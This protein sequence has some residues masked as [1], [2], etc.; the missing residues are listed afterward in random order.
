M[1]A[2]SDGWDQ[3]DG[4]HTLEQVGIRGESFVESDAHRGHFAAQARPHSLKVSHELLHRSHLFWKLERLFVQ[5]A[6]LPEGRKVEDLNHAG[7]L[8]PC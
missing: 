1:L 7:E 6:E 4:L 5:T 3:R 2:A 8:S